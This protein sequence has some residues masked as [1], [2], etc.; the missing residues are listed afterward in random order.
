MQHRRIIKRGP[1]VLATEETGAIDP[2]SHS[3]QGLFFAD[4]R[5]LSHFCATLD[6]EDLVLMGSSEEVLFEAAFIFTNSQLGDI[7]AR[8][9]GIMQHNAIGESA[10]TIK[11]TILN[12]SLQPVAFDFQIQVDADFFDSF[13][14]RGVKRVHRGE[15]LAPKIAPNGLELGYVGLDQVTRATK[16]AIS[17]PF[18]K[19]DNDML[20]FDVALE[21]DGRYEVTFDITMVEHAPEGVS[22]QPEPSLTRNPKPPWFDQGT[23]VRTGNEDVDQIIRR[24]V[25]DLEVLMTRWKD[26]W[27]P[28]AG[29]PRFDVPFGRD[30]LYTGLFTLTWNPNLAR[31]ALHFLADRQGKEENP[32]NYEQPGKIMH[33]MHTGELARLREVPFGL[34]YGSVDSTVL[35]LVLGAEYIRWTGDIKLYHELKRH[36]EA[37]WKWIDEYGNIDGTG[38]LQ[39]QA[40][41]PPKLSSAALTVGLFNQG[42]KDSANSVMY[43]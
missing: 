16:I 41:T 5:H 28:A 11:F 9:L 17:A 1:I 7:P 23:S 21:P 42:W 43:G 10:V 38:Y 3:T 20:H 37:A 26:A 32:W 25:D 40:H 19:G 6:G 24:S 27:M 36:F 18:R 2:T 31:N 12:W 35:F 30:S 29:L 4:T 14:A 33:E 8:G 34:F 22:L 39:Y 15:M 13:E